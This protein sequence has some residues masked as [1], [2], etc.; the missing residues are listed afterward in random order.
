MYY[1]RMHV[2]KLLISV[3]LPRC[4]IQG[5]EGCQCVTASLVQGKEGETKIITLLFLYIACYC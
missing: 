1:L 2:F 3:Y 4:P 5:S